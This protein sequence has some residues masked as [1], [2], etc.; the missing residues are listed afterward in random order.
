MTIL[1]IKLGQ[2]TINGYG[3]ENSFYIIRVSMKIVFGTIQ[4]QLQKTTQ[5]TKL[6]AVGFY[7]I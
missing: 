7:W 1:I 4:R 3:E 2:P 5:L 6:F